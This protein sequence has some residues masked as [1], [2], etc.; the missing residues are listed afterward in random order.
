MFKRHTTIFIFVLLFV[1]NGTSQTLEDTFEP[2]TN[3][4]DLPGSFEELWEDYDPHKEPLDIEV[5]HEWEESNIVFRVIRYRVIVAKG[6]KCM[7]AAVYG[8]P[9]GGTNLPALVNTHGGG[10]YADYRAV[11]SNAKRG[12]ATI[13]VAWAGRI[14]T[15]E[16]L[17]TAEGVQLYW[18]NA[19][20]DPDYRITTDWGALDGYHAPTKN[21]GHSSFNTAAKPYT[22]DAVESP[23][24][25]GWFLWTLAARRAITFLESQPEVD[26]TRIGVYG[27]SMGGQ[28]TVL[29]ATDPRIKAAA[30]SCGG[31]SSYGISFPEYEGTIADTANLSHITCPII[32]LSPTND[33]NG[34]YRDL[35]PATKLIKSDEWRVVSSP[36]KSHT[37][38]PEFQ[39]SGMRWFDQHLKGNFKMPESPATVLQ[40]ETNDKT[41]TFTVVPDSDKQI[42]SVD[43][44]YI[45]QSEPENLTDRNLRKFRHWHYAKAVKDGNTYKAKI[46]LESLD[47]TLWCYANI[48]YLADDAIPGAGYGYSEY[49]EDKF[50]VS[51]ATSVATPADLKAAG[52]VVTLHASLVIEDFD[53]DWK[54]DW[55]THVTSGWS[56]N[57]HKMNSSLWGPPTTGKL[58]IVLRSSHTND[59]SVS[60][61]SYKTVLSLQGDNNWDQFYLS[62]S[63][64][65]DGNG[66]AM[67]GWEPLIVFNLAPSG[68]WI[69]DDPEFKLLRWYREGTIQTHFEAE[70]ASISSGGVTENATASAGKYVDGNGGFNLLFNAEG[71]GS[72]DT[73]YFCVKVPSGTRAMGVFVNGIKAGVIASSS[74]EW[75]EHSVVTNLPAGS[76]QIELK[77]SEGSTELDVDYMRIEGIEQIEGVFIEAEDY[78]R[79]DGVDIKATEDV[80]GGLHVENIDSNDWM[81]YTIDVPYFGTYN[82]DYRITPT[83][84]GGMIYLYADKH[85]VGIDSIKSTDTSDVWLT[86]SGSSQITLRKGIQTLKIVT[87]GGGF[88]LNWLELVPDNVVETGNASINM[89]AQGMATQ[90]STVSGG[91][92][93]LAI[94]DNTNETFSLTNTEDMPWWQVELVETES[95]GGIKLFK[96]TGNDSFKNFTVTIF[97]ENGN[98]V[99]AKSYTAFPDTFLMV[100]P[101]GVSGKKVKIQL[102]GKGL[103]LSLAEVQVLKVA[104]SVSRTA[105]ILLLDD[106]KQCVGA[107]DE[108]SAILKVRGQSNDLRWDELDMGN[109]FYAYRQQNTNYCIDGGENSYDGRDVYLGECS[110]NNDNQQWLKK[111]I[112]ADTCILLKKSAMEYALTAGAGGNIHL[113]KTNVINNKQY[114]ILD[115]RTPFALNLTLKDSST[116]EILEGVDVSINGEQY[117]S[118]DVGEVAAYLSGS[119]YS[120]IL[121][122]KGYHSIFNTLDLVNDTSLAIAM[123]KKKFSFELNISDFE[124]NNALSGVSVELHNSVYMTDEKGHFSQLLEFGEYDFVLSKEG[125]IPINKSILLQNDSSIS[126]QMEKLTYR[127]AF[128]VK[129]A[130]TETIIPTAKINLNDS[131][132]ETNLF[133]SL[134]L[135]LLPNDYTYTISKEGYQ[136]ITGT[137]TLSADSTITAR[138]LVPSDLNKLDVNTVR[139]YP[140]PVS[141]FLRVTLDQPASFHLYGLAGELKHSGTLNAGG[142]FIDV[143]ALASG[144]YWMII[145]VDPNLVVRK[146]IIKQ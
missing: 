20:S 98:D 44:Y 68:T 40:L 117:L 139:V 146:V 51:S 12:Y 132:Y 16:Y 91:E 79:M 15:P 85:L 70:D 77:D 3:S 42:L 89:A 119:E 61:G 66:S 38:F 137:F 78:I 87:V 73:L 69:G 115:P 2:I 43:V 37:D 102:N 1:L 53:E 5:L 104:G 18:D 81:E 142:S 106:K 75:E 52:S 133:G 27:H 11:R 141:D 136:D 67:S 33:F 84:K 21:E 108:L 80:D 72:V 17:V 39:V 83:K 100:Y 140:N 118:N 19:I 49:E 107:N 97:D 86:Q 129:D 109:G 145:K 138:L 63:D 123:E 127:L 111:Q 6:E 50:N 114:W 31:I 126:L 125:F 120:I 7:V 30:P 22:I 48:K 24:N 28:I 45:Q 46:P 14:R 65:K 47:K 93:A 71:V 96:N 101:G 25:S 35:T 121:S 103:A 134:S 99:F 94:D 144:I 135:V 92:A 116:K 131:V 26:S 105:Q 143:K 32:F 95:I 110:T 54:K 88:S 56:Y 74:R 10:Q 34:F 122:K 128:R 8:Y 29:T 23:R 124:T 4:E 41:P 64:F 62:P 59:I 130:A 36:Y 76:C 60:Y 13:S 9:K 113:D 57:T 90:S 55:Y 82:V 58:K 112:G